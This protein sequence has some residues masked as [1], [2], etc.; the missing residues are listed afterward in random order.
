[1]SPRQSI[2]AL[3]D[4]RLAAEQGTIFKVAPLRVALVYPSPYRIG[5]SSL[6][7]QTIYR[8]LNG[9]PD[10]VCE[11]AFLPDDVE[12]WRRSRSPLLTYESR[13]P[14]AD[15]DVVAFSLAY[16]L[17]LTGVFEC[18][19]L[20][21]IPILAEDRG[22]RT[23]LVVI[24]GPL[25]FSNPVPAAPFADV[26]LMG[27]AEEA[28]HVL[29]DAVLEGDVKSR[30]PAMADLEG[31]YVPE[32]HGDA[33]RPVAKASAHKL[34]A[35]SQ[36]L[37]PHTELSNMHLVESERG[38]SRKCTFCVM[39]RSTNGGMR[40]ADVDTIMATVPEAARKVGLVGAA[41]SD[42]PALIDIVRAI[43]DSGREIGL[44]SLRADR[45][46]P[47]LME[48]LKRGGYRTVTVAS[49]GAS[50]R[51]RTMMMKHIGERHLRRAAELV[52][53]SGIGQLKV[54]MMIGVP[55]ETDED[56]D[57]LVRFSLELAK[58]TPVAMGIAPFV[59]KR[60]TPLDRQPFAGIKEVER[61]LKRLRLGLGRHVDLRS[62]SARWA[63]VEYVLAQGDRR[64][65]LATLEAW[66]NGAGF[67]AWKRAFGGLEPAPHT[68]SP[69]PMVP[70]NRAERL[71]AERLA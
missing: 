41:V 52:R 36:I 19:E 57:E 60:N 44:S 46:T 27:E 43:V 55:N 8:E 66:R 34:P 56:L 48:L 12:A 26:I 45:L 49:D 50:D 70:T 3:I 15:F 62:T 54:Y 7:F 10:T 61:T 42:H 65:G 1:M 25:T 33:L 16:E 4:E 22:P 71:A 58:I 64:T 21:G 53:D 23:P 31:F 69:P 17:E 32:V 18:L 5:M 13:R 11:R 9:R 28:I 20:S 37:T 59:A 14:V 63:W 40:L 39:R 2:H 35:Y 67:G 68:F 30:L 51:L 47:E 6:G 24:G 29:L 38:C